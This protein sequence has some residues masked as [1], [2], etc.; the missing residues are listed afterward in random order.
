MNSPASGSRT[1]LDVISTLHERV[2]CRQEKK[3]PEKPIGDC[4]FMPPNATLARNRHVGDYSREVRM[5]PATALAPPIDVKRPSRALDELLHV[6]AT[7]AERRLYAQVDFR[8]EMRPI[9]TDARYTGIASLLVIALCATFLGWRWDWRSLAPASPAH[10]P[11]PLRITSFPVCCGPETTSF[12]EQ[13]ARASSRR[14]VCLIGDDV[15][16]I[17]LAEAIY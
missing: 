11:L 14:I 2:V 4:G 15:R 8:H 10:S 12:P 16:L 6:A 3:I 1:S 13:G 17:E 9:T 7:T 5:H